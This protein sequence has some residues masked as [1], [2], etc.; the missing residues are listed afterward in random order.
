MYDILVECAELSLDMSENAGSSSSVERASSQS[1][2]RKCNFNIIINIVSFCF[3]FSFSFT[4]M[5]TVSQHLFI[6]LIQLARE[7]SLVDVT[8]RDVR[9]GFFK[10]S[11][12]LRKTA[13]S[14][15]FVD[16]L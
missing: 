12:V 13:G 2:P 10:F 9:N 4:I 6:S 5:K 1:S 8:I 14:V 7:E 15:F 3:S 16:Q 11:S